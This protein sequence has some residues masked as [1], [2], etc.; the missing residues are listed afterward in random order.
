MLSRRPLKIVIVVALAVFGVSGFLG[1]LAD[2]DA[3]QALPR[4]SNVQAYT[5]EAPLANATRMTIRG[6]RLA[7]GCSFQPPTLSLGAGEKA[8]AARQ[9]SAD[10]GNCTTVVEIGTPTQVS[11][12]MRDEVL[13]GEGVV[14]TSDTRKVQSRMRA[15]GTSQA[16][17]KIT[18]YDTVGLSLNYTRSILH[19][20]WN[21]SCV[22]GSTHT[23]ATWQQVAT[24]WQ[25]SSVSGWKDTG[26]NSHFGHVNSQF[27]NWPFCI[28]P[29]VRIYY[30]DVRI[31]GGYAGGYGG[32]L[33]ST[34]QTGACAP[35][36]W[37]AELVKEY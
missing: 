21:G 13:S 16:Y 28:P 36:H 32:Y 23:W 14:H 3:A 15:M 26:C 24:G 33:G 27:V 6:T 10:L 37:G 30:N 4:A 1:V 20:V 11:P 2:G 19:W 7:G 29:P 9:V 31:R 8:I 17:Y 18:W 5:Y 34:Y 35:L 12:N 22:L 25:L